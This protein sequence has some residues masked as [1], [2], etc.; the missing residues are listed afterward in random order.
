MTKLE[1]IEQ[2]IQGL[3]PQELDA[4][5]KWFHAYDAQRWDKQ[6][7]RDVSAGR[8]ERLRQ[9]AVTEHQDQRSREL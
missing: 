5:R 7:E 6:I 2:D 4:F 8:L 1:K 9:E 3:S